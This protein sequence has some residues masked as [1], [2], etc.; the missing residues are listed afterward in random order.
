[1][2]SLDVFESSHEYDECPMPALNAPSLFGYD[3][4]SKID[5]NP[6]PL[7]L[8]LTKFLT[9][10]SQRE[11][12]DGMSMYELHQNAILLLEAGAII[13]PTAAKYLHEL[14]YVSEQYSYEG[15]S[16]GAEKEVAHASHG[17]TLST[18]CH[19]TPWRVRA[20]ALAPEHRGLVAA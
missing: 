20:C 19:P 14:Q 13:T 15:R 3:L 18:S 11:A 12:I 16:W 1:M 5:G 7:E 17:C 2:R 8:C 4:E 10:A 6:T 9:V